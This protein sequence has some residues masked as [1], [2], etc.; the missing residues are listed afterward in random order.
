ML[1]YKLVTKKRESCFVHGTEHSLIYNK[2]AVVVAPENTVGIFCFDSVE[3]LRKFQK[4]TG[5][6]TIIL[7]VN[8]IGKPRHPRFI[9]TFYSDIES[10]HRSIKLNGYRKTAFRNTLYGEELVESPQGTLCFRKVKVL[11]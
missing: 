5:H 1:A 11:E 6:G 2:D 7:K 3:N 10:Y 9:P 4:M 8:G